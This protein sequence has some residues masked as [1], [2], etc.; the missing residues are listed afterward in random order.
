MANQMWRFPLK[1]EKP[2]PKSTAKKGRN[3]RGLA[4]TAKKPKREMAAASLANL[5]KGSTKV[6]D[7]DEARER[8]NEASQ[9]WRRETSLSGREIGPLPQK[10]NWERRLRCKTSLKEFCETYLKPV[11]YLGWSNDQLRCVDKIE[12]VFLDGGQFAIAMPRGGGK[13]AMVRAGTLWGTAFAYR[14]F[15]FLVGSSAEKSTQTLDFIRTYWYMNPLLLED[16][17]E[18][19]Y[20]IKK[21]QNR[22]HLAKG[23]IFNGFPTHIEWGGE[24]IMYP[25]LLLSREGAEGYLEHDPS[26]VREIA[27]EGATWWMPSSG[28]TI[29]RTSGIDGSIRGEAEVHPILLTQPRPDLVILDDVQ[30]DQKADSPASCDKLIRLIDGAVQG[31]AGPGE[32]IG[33]LMPC[34]VAREGDVSDTYLD[35]MK[36]PEWQGERCRLVMSWPDGITDIDISLE[37]E[38]SKLWNQ[39]AELRRLS[40]RLHGNIDLATQFYEANRELMDKNFVCSWSERYQ[41]KIELSAQ[42]HAMNLRLTNGETFPAEYQNRGRKPDN[43]GVVPIT[44]DMLAEKTVAYPKRTLPIDTQ[45]LVAFVDVQNEGFFYTVF[46]CSPDFTGVFTDYG[47]FPEVNSRIFQRAMLDG[48]SVLSREFYKAYP[49]LAATAHK[50]E[51]GRL[52]APLEA[53]I[54]HGLGLMVR[55]LLTREYFKDDS[56]RTPMRIQ[57]IAIDARWGD[58]T[59]VIKRFCREYG[60][61]T[62]SVVAPDSI[63]DFVP[64]RDILI[65]YIGQYVSPV[66]KQFEEY[67]RTPGWLFEDQKSPQVKEIKWIYKP[68]ASGQYYLAADVNRLKSFLMARLASPPG[69]PGCISLFDAPPEIHEMFARH[70]CDSE[71]PETIIAKNRTKD[72]WQLREG[73]P[74]ND[75]LDGAAGCMALASY[76]GAYIRTQAAGPSQSSTRKLSQQWHAKRQKQR[77]D[78]MQTQAQVQPSFRQ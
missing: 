5:R 38:E 19:A 63:D 71:Y 56:V 28:G 75:Y 34:T 14:N 74:D 58:V 13:T 3:T 16:F 62:K 30:K 46:A 41:K 8:Q 67:T 78:Q 45:Y 20:P 76:M 70:I 23:Q 66:H 4:K 50:T 35:M 33:C 12:R 59:D 49:N 72:L 29:I 43:E 15:P 24:S 7:S 6:L 26:S 48:W 73:K 31:L 53:K 47:V 32:R 17:P 52:R 18:I 9:K 55:H 57:K 36:K 40:L 42:Q 37:T 25:S 64:A 11:F 65:P 21:L 27:Y 1:S 44:S 10:I 51:G 61:R 68:D 69:S 22:W 77:I 2:K 39:Y 54:Y 60:S